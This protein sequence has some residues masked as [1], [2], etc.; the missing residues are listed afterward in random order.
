MY[1]NYQVSFKYD[2]KE[3]SQSIDSS[4]DSQNVDINVAEIAVKECMKTIEKKKGVYPY[5]IVLFFQGKVI[6]RW[7]SFHEK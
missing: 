5:D 4:A 1:N 7:D 6:A 3:Y 2:G